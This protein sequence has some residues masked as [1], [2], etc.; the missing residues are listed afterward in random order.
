MLPS[1]VVAGVEYARLAAAL[2]VPQPGH[3]QVECESL[4][5]L[6]K[7]VHQRLAVARGTFRDHSNCVTFTAQVSFPQLQRDAFWVRCLRDHNRFRAPGDTCHQRQIA[8]MSALDL[9]ERCP[10]HRRGGNPKVVDRSQR[11]IDFRGCADAD[12]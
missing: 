11:H 10:S 8:P 6:V 2:D 7:I 12:V 1:V 5:L 4:L 9:H 3:A